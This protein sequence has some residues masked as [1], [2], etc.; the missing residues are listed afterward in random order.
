[1]RG[2][3]WG[4]EGTGLG[5]PRKPGTAPPHLLRQRVSDWDGPDHCILHA[6]AQGK[7][8]DEEERR[9]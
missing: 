3:G 2:A 6:G 8:T 5:Q 9:L 1:M 4:R 7:G